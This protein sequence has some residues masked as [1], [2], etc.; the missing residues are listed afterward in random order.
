MEQARSDR[1]CKPLRDSNA[2]ICRI[3]CCFIII[4]IGSVAKNLVIL[5]N[6]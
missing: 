6:N 1:H 3:A 5:Q 4:V 2:I